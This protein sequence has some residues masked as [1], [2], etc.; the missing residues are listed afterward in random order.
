M[1]FQKPPKEE[2]GLIQGMA[3]D[4]KEEWWVAL[5]LWKH[6]VPFE[7]QWQIA[8]GRSRAGGIIVDFVVYNPMKTPLPV[9][10][11]Y[12][13]KGEMKGADK[14]DL[15]AIAQHF[16]FPIENIPVLWAADSETKEDVE[17]W[18]KRN[19]VR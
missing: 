13:H 3:P 16:K 7:F 14:M 12:W 18:V 4:S 6:E 10:G 5:A 1:I 17:A 19:V 11:S 15:I 9:H 2:I 8:G